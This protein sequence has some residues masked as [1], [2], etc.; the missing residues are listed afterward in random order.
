MSA[1]NTSSRRPWL[2]RPMTVAVD[3][4]RTSARLGALILLLMVPSIGATYAY[5]GQINGQ[6]DFARSELSGT[7]VVRQ[8]LLAMA[9]TVGG[10]APDLAPLR[11]AARA[12]PE[13]G[14]ADELAAVEAAATGTPAQRAE[15][16]AALAALITEA[17][18]TSKLILDPDLDSFYVMDLHIVQ[19]PKALAAAATATALGTGG[20]VAERAVSA[21]DLTSAARAFRS[22]VDTARKN[23]KMADLAGRMASLAA[24]ADAADALAA[25]ITGSL[26]SPVALE[27][28]PLGGAVRAAVGPAADVL[29]D[30]LTTRRD[31]LLAERTL[32]LTLTGLAALIAAWFA[33]TVWWRT[34][35]D[36]AVVLSRVKA[37]A[38]G[39]FTARPLPAGRDELGDIGGAV[40]TARDRLA[41]QER[42]LDEARQVREN[43]VHE[44][45][46]HQRQAEYRLRERAQKLID[47]SAGVIADELGLVADQVDEV[48]TA[49][50]TIDERVSAANRAT[51]AVVGQAREAEPVIAALEASL[52]QV[53]GMAE[54]IAGIAGQTRLLAL[55]ATIEAARAGRTGLGFA[56]VANEVKDLAT[57][58]AQSTEQIT[59][60]IGSLERDA[61]E[62]AA[63]IAAM[64]AGI[65]EIDSTTAVL[66]T[67]AA[68]Q[69]EVV[70]RLDDRLTGTV[71][72]IRGLSALAA[73]LERREADRLSTSGP[74]RLRVPGRT[75][76]YAGTLVDL[77]TGGFRCR[78]G[79]GMRLEAGDVVEAEVQ[80]R[81]EPVRIRARVVH[82][83]AGAD[84]TEAGLQFVDPDPATAQR[85]ADHVANLFDGS[86]D[87]SG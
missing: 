55:N 80:L 20:S 39:D 67:V 59:A 48:R 25:V 66:H 44:T 58:V 37:L 31:A 21:G 49:A 1:T 47:E 62:M 64:V 32:T 22:D 16:A 79:A 52:R 81:G 24:A 5:I 57:N 86:V 10:V 78:L 7:V 17:G 51:G 71:G 35:A 56:V 12:H 54:V 83:Q 26:D 14:L 75:D 8:A 50:A 69:R 72:R 3:R 87:A 2:V 42:D 41:A 34:R 84:T 85:I 38:A 15:R 53:A 18:N 60:T 45:F 9:A 40:A 19:I 30:L 43:Q 11:A 76:P 61:A 77:S 70:G 29:T 36:V 63:A 82:V 73:Q 27:P 46:L 74:V 68:E 28:A 65:G 23:T 13:L 6:V 4:M 33:A